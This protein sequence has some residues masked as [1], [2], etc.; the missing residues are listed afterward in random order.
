VR[1]LIR[2]A[3]ASLVSWTLLVGPVSAATNQAT[4]VAQAAQ[5][6]TITGQVTTEGGAGLSGASVLLE[7]AGQRQTTT[8]D[9]SGNFTFS[10][11]PG[12]Y[13]ITVVKGGYQ[14]GSN[15]VTVASGTSVSVNVGLTQASLNNLNTI[16]RTS[17]SGGGNAA[18]FNISA[19]QTQTLTQQQLLVRQTPDLV[20]LLQELPGVTIP[21]ATSNPNQSF[22]IRGLRYETKVTIDGHPISSSTLGTFLTNYTAASIFGGVDVLQ[23]AGLNGPL[24]GE[25]GAGLV[26]LRTPDFAAKDGGFIQGGLDSYQ[27]SI[28]TAIANVNLFNNKLQF[29]FGRAFSGYRGPTYDHQEPNV[30]LGTSLP[31]GTGAPAPNITNGTIQYISDFSDTYA[32]NA[33]LAKMRF[34]F[35]DATSLAFEFLGLQGGFNP[36]GGAY[37]QF[38][39]YMTVPQCVNAGVAASGAACTATSTYNSPGAQYLI[40]QTGVPVYGFFPGSAVSYNQPNFNADFKTTFKNDTILFRP[41]SAY[42][43]RLIDGTQEVAVPGQKSTWS[44]V[45]NSANCNVVYL[46]PTGPA[47]A[48]GPC[49]AANTP[50][51]SAYVTN[52]QVSHDF[53]TTATPLVCTPTTP[54]YTTQTIESNAGSYGFGTPY[55]TLEL[56]RLFGYTFNYIHPVGANTYNLSFD[57]Y[58]DDSE[59]FFN[60]ASTLLPGCTFVL[61]A[62]ANTPGTAGYQ[63]NCPFATLQASPINVPETFASVSS[64]GI[65]A[66]LALTSKLEFDVGGY[67]THYL[68]NAQQ[69]NPA[70]IAPYL[71]TGRQTAAPVSL[72]NSTNAAAHF[73]P[74]FGLLFRP[75]KDLVFRFTGGSSMTI[76]YS[77][78]VSGFPNYNQGSTSTTITS[79]N[80][81]LLPE[82][83]VSLDIGS[84]LRLPGGTVLSGD[85]YNTVVHNPWISTKVQQCNSI[86]TCAVYF[87]PNL[88]T[89]NAGY[90]SQ[91]FNGAQQYAQ[92]FEIS[93]TNEPKV[94]FGYR[95][96]TSFERLY[97]LQTPSA[98]FASPEVFFNGNQFQ[99]IGSTSTS[100]PYAKGYGE[101]QYAGANKSLFRVGADY[102]GNNN[103]Y[104]I[105]AFF[106]FDAGAK[107]N[108]GFHDV[109]VGLTVENLILNPIGNLLA[110]GVE[111]AGLEPVAATASPGGYTYSTGTFNSAQV[112][113]GPITFRMTL[114]KQ[115]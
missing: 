2:A 49:Y 93:A 70:V 23:G 66:Q 60:D 83:V 28:Y 27:G 75:T 63:P 90:T 9:D 67:F 107:V 12:L 82:E 50:P 100:V 59:S 31:F 68:I 24:S 53:A 33:E 103:E 86:A 85:L 112:S 45:T 37:G 92:G 1:T 101:V 17:S 110:R 40:G 84:D 47:G 21:R 41:Y 56:D 3:L 38:V 48:T 7:G 81:T 55:T 77:G 114:S 46:A 8:S 80:F 72:I 10:A 62:S 111:Y 98:F 61:L 91:T 95:L 13:T 94:G 4:T 97:Y 87:G 39:G 113:P 16:G 32:L 52:P 6:G 14:T 58:Y 11:P 5:A 29:V 22:I 19:N 15:D 89:T 104:N 54:C 35:S 69:E 115:F 79:P 36:Q 109:M 71:A 57:H 102:E 88:E 78:L 20:N 64:L 51:V 43:N 18:K 44:E 108:T 96:N 26:N 34:N 42:I 30:A 99:Q 73:D 74:H 106:I 76:P 65:S 25:A 105:P